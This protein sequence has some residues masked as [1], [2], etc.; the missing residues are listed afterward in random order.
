MSVDRPR[1]Q[2]RLDLPRPVGQV[3]LGAELHG[4]QVAGQVWAGSV[5]GLRRV[6]RRAG[7]DAEVRA[8]GVRFPLGDLERVAAEDDVRLV[9]GP[10][11]RPVVGLLDDPPD[12]RHPA[13]LERTGPQLEL[14]WRGR[15]QDYRVSMTAS[16]AAALLT[17]DIAFVAT[18]AAWAVLERDVSL[19]PL[20]GTARLNDDGYVEI[21]A[22]APQLVEAAPLPALFRV[23]ATHF[24]VPA[25]YADEVE[26]TPG[27]R[28]EGPRPTDETP[29]RW[30]A[31][32]AVLSLSASQD[33]DDIVDRVSQTGAAAVVYDDGLERRLC[34]L[35]A[36]EVVDAWPAVI[37]AP[38]S[39]VWVWQRH[40]QLLGRRATVVGASGADAQIVTYYDLARI[41]GL[42]ASAS[43][44]FDALSSEEASAERL[45]AAGRRLDGAGDLVRVLVERTW[46]E[47]VASQ[48]SWLDLLRPGEFRFQG[49][50]AARYP[51]DPA[52]RF[53]EHAAC[54]LLRRRVGQAPEVDGLGRM[55]QS[56]VEVLQP[57]EVQRKA[58]A[59]LAD[60]VAAGADP[61]SL[62]PEAVQ[63]TTVGTEEEP[64]PKL[65]AAVARLR[66]AAAQGRSAVVAVAHDRAA[67][68]LQALVRPLRP[69]VTD[70]GAPI[71]RLSIVRFNQRL[72]D[73]R[74][75]DEVVLC[76]YPFSGAEIDRAVGEPTEPDVPAEVVVLHLEGSVDDRLALLAARRREELF[77][78]PDAPSAAEARWLLWPR[79]A[80]QADAVEAPEALDQ[81]PPRRAGEDRRR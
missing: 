50:A 73:L 58:A 5:D 21:L 80:A 46:P 43:V 6:L 49:P 71:A 9:P 70:G 54:Y 45:R 28:W 78:E 27:F 63:R 17:L 15:D 12:A 33:V 76:D 1:F 57:T 26:R 14:R 24:G 19:P 81:P 62:L 7:V 38:P 2:S 30:P 18:D 39:A 56:H 55:P 13:V 69:E 77:P 67:E 48:A 3:V 44:V 41:T 20:A 32:P 23:D 34:A 75:F 35:T 42:G 10:S 68:R 16:A 40:L 52:A 59:R 64:S 4:L 8:D 25:C 29:S 74:G 61:Q 11:L 53:A 37:A 31:L 47:D 22:H 72:P 60:E 79:L 66:Q 51:R 65:L 36:L